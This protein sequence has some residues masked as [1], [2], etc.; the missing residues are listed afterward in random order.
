[1]VIVFNNISREQLPRYATVNG[2]FYPPLPNLPEL[3]VLC[4]RYFYGLLDVSLI[5]FKIVKTDLDKH[6]RVVLDF[7]VDK[8]IYRKYPKML[9]YPSNVECVE[10]DY[11]D[12][13]SEDSL[14]SLIEKKKTKLKRSWVSKSREILFQ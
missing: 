10:K 6:G 12:F 2:F 14:F 11:T 13:D 1:M 3:N 4:R 9:S 7:N 5:G 8:V